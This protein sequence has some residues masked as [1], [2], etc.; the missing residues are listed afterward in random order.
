MIAKILELHLLR[1][2]YVHVQYTRFAE[3]RKMI[4]NCVFRHALLAKLGG[5]NMDQA[6]HNGSQILFECLTGNVFHRPII[7]NKCLCIDSDCRNITA[8]PKETPDGTQKLTTYPSTNPL[9]IVPYQCQSEPLY[10]LACFNS[11]VFF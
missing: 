8:Q 9:G 4:K 1:Y 11:T 5:E 10:T 7:Y 3:Y 2:T 6:T